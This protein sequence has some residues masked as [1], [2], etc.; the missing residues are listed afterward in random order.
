[1]DDRGAEIREDHGH[2]G[3]GDVLAK[4]D[5]LD[6]IEG[7]LAELSHDSPSLAKPAAVRTF[8][9]VSD[10]RHTKSLL[11]RRNWRRLGVVLWEKWRK[12][13]SNKKKPYDTIFFMAG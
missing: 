13:E 3:P 4:V 7:E 5:D 11:Y 2:G 1:M 9:V 12:A 6:A 10:R 8:V